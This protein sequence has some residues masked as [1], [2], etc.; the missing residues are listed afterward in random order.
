MNPRNTTA[1]E[2]YNIIKKRIL[3]LEYKP[4]LALSAL[5]LSEEMNVSRSPAREALIKLSADELVEIF[6]QKGTRVT[7]INLNKVS[8]ERFLRKSLEEF[9]LRAFHEKHSSRDIAM[10]KQILEDQRQAWEDQDYVSF[11]NMDNEFH[12][13]IFLSISKPR[14]WSLIE[15]FASNEFRIRLLSC[16]YVEKT[17][18]IVLQNHTDLVNA[19][20]AGDL[21]LSLEITHQHLSRISNEIP[22]LIEEHP[23]IFSMDSGEYGTRY[24]RNISSANSNFLDSV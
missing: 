17:T 9:A 6:P 8:E 11:I 16:R 4:G 21:D 5:T 3:H 14:C 15:S 24:Q 13:C 10:M 19:L 20:E 18:D 1:E 2:I 22:K 23:E 12:K 7:L